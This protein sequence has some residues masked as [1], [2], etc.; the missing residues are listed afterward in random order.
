MSLLKGES[1]NSE[2]ITTAIIS[3]FTVNTFMYSA[4]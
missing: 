2:N 4:H 1:K 3:Y